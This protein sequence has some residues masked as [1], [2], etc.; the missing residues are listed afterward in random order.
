MNNE[1]VRKIIR[2]HMEKPGYNLWGSDGVSGLIKKWAPELSEE[3]RV[4][5]VLEE[6]R[7]STANLESEVAR[8][9]AAGVGR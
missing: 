3:E 4:R 9:V 2:N 8:L 1:I 6:F 7:G 5:L